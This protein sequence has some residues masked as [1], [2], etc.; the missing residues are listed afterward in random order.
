MY[1]LE[2]FRVAA[3][4]LKVLF[5]LLEKRKA[6]N[7]LRDWGPRASEKLGDTGLLGHYRNVFE[8]RS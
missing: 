4:N 8:D 1:W 5:M 7:Q 3:I 2:F 6:S